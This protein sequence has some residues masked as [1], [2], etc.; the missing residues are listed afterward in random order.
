MRAMWSRLRPAGKL[1]SPLTVSSNR[2]RHYRY[3]DAGYGGVGSH[4]RT[5]PPGRWRENHCHVRGGRGSADSYLDLALKF[6]AAGFSGSLLRE[7]SPAARS[8]RLSVNLRKMLSA[9][10]QSKHSTA[11]RHVTMRT[12]TTSSQPPNQL[13]LLR[14]GSGRP[15]TGRYIAI[16]DAALRDTAAQTDGPLRSQ[17]VP[18]I[19]MASGLGLAVSKGNCNGP[20]NNAGESS[21]AGQTPSS[22][23]GGWQRYERG[24]GPAEHE[25]LLLV[26]V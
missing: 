23:H 8:R 26:I 13:Q 20:L 2:C 1:A 18:E 6:G 24:R 16:F 22:S 9:K 15:R 25:T 5:A 7:R 3:R 4:S 10:S 14:M 12:V 19:P 17:S 21:T 11:V